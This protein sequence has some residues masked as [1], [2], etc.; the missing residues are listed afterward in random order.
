MVLNVQQVITIRVRTCISMVD[1]LNISNL[2]L[3]KQI[4][5]CLLLV[6]FI[7]IHTA[8]SSNATF[9]NTISD[10]F[11]LVMRHPQIY[12]S[13]FITNLF[14]RVRHHFLLNIVDST[15]LYLTHFRSL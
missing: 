7:R 2:I 13:G 5:S 11:K 15:L 10:V 6:I 8:P 4:L 14:L 1:T 9:I 12:I 3:L